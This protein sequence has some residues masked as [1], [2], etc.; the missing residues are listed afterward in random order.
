MP[1]MSSKIFIS[2][3]HITIR[4]LLKIY[5]NCQGEKE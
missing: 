5:E 4:I 2:Q 1:I 3:I